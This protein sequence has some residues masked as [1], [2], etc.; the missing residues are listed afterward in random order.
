MPKIVL[1]REKLI[2][3]S[4]MARKGS[5]Y[6]C[7]N[8]FYIF[9]FDHSCLKSASNVIRYL[10]SL[11]LVSLKKLIQVNSSNALTESL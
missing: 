10:T 11:G 5:N 7:T 9:L 8:F 6:F 2:F 4:K 1:N 3:N